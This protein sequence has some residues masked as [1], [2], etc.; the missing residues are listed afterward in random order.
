MKSFWNCKNTKDHL[1]AEALHSL[2]T[3]EK[4]CKKK[5][6]LLHTRFDRPMKQILALFFFS[7]WSFTL[8]SQNTIQAPQPLCLSG[9]TLHWTLPTNSCGPFIEYEIY[10]STS[11]AGPFALIATVADPL[12]TEYVDPNPSSETRYYFMRSNY[13]CPGW[14]APPSDTISNE[15]PSDVLIS[16]VTVQGEQVLIQWANNN[17]PQTSAYLVYREIGGNVDLIDTVF[18][19]LQYLDLSANPQS[20]SETYYLLAMDPCGNTSAFVSPHHSIFLQVDQ[21]FCL[22]QMQ[23]SWNEYQGWPAGVSTYQ[24][25][26]SKDGEPYQAVANLPKGSTTYN[27]QNLTTGSEYCFY[28]EALA[29]GLTFSSASNVVCLS[30]NVAPVPSQL[31]LLNA[32]V[33]PTNQ[34]EISWQWDEELPYQSARLNWNEGSAITLDVLPPL[35]FTNSFLHEQAKPEEGPLEYALWVENECGESF[36]GG[37]SRTVFLQAKALSEGVVLEWTPFLLS[38][39]EVSAYR[40][41]REEEGQWQM[42]QQL[43]PLQLEFLDESAE[44]TDISC[45]RIEAVY[46]LS[47]PDGSLY[48][49]T[50]FSNIACAIPEV[51]VYLPN[52]F[53]PEG[54]NNRFLPGLAAAD[55]LLEYELQ[56][57]DRYGQLLFQTNDPKVGWNGSFRGQPMPMDTYVYRLRLLTYGGDLLEKKGSLVLLR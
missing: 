4:G 8:L 6:L 51:K 50:S 38:Q 35:S 36:F 25:W 20:G 23:L 42:L 10:R 31:A 57:F 41:Y 37:Q 7:I 55:I 34:V 1:Q 13:D 49:N 22:R 44:P 16:F 53:A 45:Y 19:A 30:A 18:N 24:I 32:S 46:Q 17:S 52:V 15:F 29:E 21:D 11:S 14:T 26:M 40:V 54:V 56:I 43:S 2:K 27:F 28:I 9:D 47:L 12:L 39:A 48:S 3:K 5:G 33:S